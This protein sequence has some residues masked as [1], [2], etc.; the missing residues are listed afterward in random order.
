MPMR[1][2]CIGIAV[3]SLACAGL[4]QAQ[5]AAVVPADPLDLIPQPAKVPAPPAP[6]PSLDTT[7]PAG[8]TPV[9]STPV[10]P[11]Q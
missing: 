5:R 4:A 1:L 10:P 8:A 9:D 6:K 2:S 11:A 3:A 7:T